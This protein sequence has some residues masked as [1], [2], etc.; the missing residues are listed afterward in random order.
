MDVSLIAAQQAMAR[1]NVALSVM[2]QS[3]DM[4]GQV[5]DILAQSLEVSPS[6]R[7]GSVDF[8]A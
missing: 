8:T 2:K 6:G 5:A 7:G 3:A 4:Q 1:Q